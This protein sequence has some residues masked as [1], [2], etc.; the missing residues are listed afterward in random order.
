MAP[1]E[2][3]LT[4]TT[5]EKVGKEA[6]K[7]IRVA[8]FF[9][10]PEAVLEAA[11]RQSFMNVN[12][13][14]PGVRAPAEPELLDGIC[15][16]VAQMASTHLN[17]PD[18]QW[19]GQAWYSIVTQTPQ[20]LLPLQRLPHFDGLDEEQVAVMIYLNH[21]EHGGT[22]FFRHKSSGFEHVTDRRFPD[23]RTQLES[24]VASSGMP[25][26]HYVTSG[27]PYFEKIA[28]FGAEFNSLI[29]YP[30]TLL[31]SGVIDNEAPLP[32]DAKTGRFTLNG[33]FKPK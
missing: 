19:Q 7:I 26:A 32:S 23:Y 2:I 16:S 25:D 28:D 3:D 22:A 31:H 5:V 17:R 9:A 15:T 4:N 20:K 33:F 12:S 10:Q 6:T 27:E 13:L 18:V 11:S 29:L 24:E 14:F 1:I 8:N 21:T 30:S